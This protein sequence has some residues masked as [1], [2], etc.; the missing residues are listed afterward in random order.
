MCSLADYFFIVHLENL[1]SAKVRATAGVQAPDHSPV[2][3]R[4]APWCYV[5]CK[6]SA[7][8]NSAPAVSPFTLAHSPTS[9]DPIHWRT[10][11]YKTLS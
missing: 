7:S 2:S 4:Y 6:V 9:P 8:W 5:A 11:E 10:T 3:L 1:G